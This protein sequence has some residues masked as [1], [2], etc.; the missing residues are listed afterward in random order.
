[1]KMTKR[2]R[3]NTLSASPPSS[4]SPS[5]SSSSSSPASAS[6]ASITTATPVIIRPS[7][8]QRS[9]FFKWERPAKQ[10]NHIDE[11]YNDGTDLVS[12]A[13]GYFP[14]TNSTASE[15]S[16]SGSDIDENKDEDEDHDD[17]E[18]NVKCLD[19]WEKGYRDPPS[20]PAA[21]PADEEQQ[22]EERLS[23]KLTDYE[24]LTRSG[25][26]SRMREDDEGGAEYDVARWEE[27]PKPED[28][29]H[30]AGKNGDSTLTTQDDTDCQEKHKDGD[31]AP[32]TRNKMTMQRQGKV[33]RDESTTPIHKD[34]E[35]SDHTDSDITV[36]SSTDSDGEAANCGVTNDS[37]EDSHGS[38]SDNN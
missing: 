10:R 32:L 28:V 27:Y 13:D 14:D 12:E 22:G 19:L 20:S 7:M 37:D 15:L 31:V 9:T 30:H 4:S 38:E 2:H 21:E 18:N 33:D 17:S 8:T 29:L 26:N 35:D 3:L 11:D 6:A 34:A 23:K 25:T 1:M 16:S 24:D 5:P 36:I